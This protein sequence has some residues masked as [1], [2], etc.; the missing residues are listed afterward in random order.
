MAYEVLTILTLKYDGSVQLPPQPVV[1]GGVTRV[2]WEELEAPH[3]WCCAHRNK[4]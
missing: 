1:E 4:G 3:A 2:R